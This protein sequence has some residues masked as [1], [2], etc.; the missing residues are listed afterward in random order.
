M[1]HVQE[2][3]KLDEL[4]NILPGCEG[5]KLVFTATKREAD[6]VEM[7]LQHDGSQIL[8]LRTISFLLGIRALA[9]HGDK[10]QREREYALRSFRKGKIDTLVA[11]DVAARGLDIPNV[12]WVIQYDLPSSNFL[13]LFL[14]PSSEVFIIPRLHHTVRVQNERF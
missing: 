7:E 6:R 11:T 5:L 3:D 8:Q 2:R 12:L 4:F 14:I 10:S 13:K 1:R 9:I